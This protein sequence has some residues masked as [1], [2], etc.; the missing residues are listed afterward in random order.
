MRSVYKK[1]QEDTLVLTALS[2]MYEKI[3]VDHMYCVFIKHVFLNMSGFLK[4]H[5]LLQRPSENYR[6]FEKHD[7]QQTDVALAVEL[8]NT[9]DCPQS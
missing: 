5:F 6:A 9:F 4:Q 1:K 7:K 8:E 2:K 3:L